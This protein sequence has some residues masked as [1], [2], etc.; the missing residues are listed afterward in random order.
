MPFARYIA[1][2]GITCFR[3]FLI[4]RVYR[5]KKVFGFLPRELY[6]CAFDIVTPT[7]GIQIIKKKIKN[8]FFTLIIGN[9]MADAELLYILNEI[10]DNI[11]VL[12]N[13]NFFLQLNH[14]SLLKSILLHCGIKE[15]Y[16]DVYNI[17]SKA[18]VN[19]SIQS[20]FQKQ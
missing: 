16:E 19:V 18:K 10:V 3:R 6:E 7:P 13:K 8:N 14:T 15:K 12:R 4:E 5:E 9:F 2:N 20:D 11:L 17:L 1:W